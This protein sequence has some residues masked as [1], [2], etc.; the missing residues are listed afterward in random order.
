LETLLETTGGGAG[1]VPKPIQIQGKDYYV[2][3]GIISGSTE[4]GDVNLVFELYDQEPSFTNGQ[5]SVKPVQ[6][7]QCFGDAETLYN[8]KRTLDVVEATLPPA[9]L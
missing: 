1:E 8:L 4:T 6:T 9:P 3:H 2:K 7:I 5:A